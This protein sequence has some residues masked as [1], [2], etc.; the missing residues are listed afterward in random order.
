MLLRRDGHRVEVFGAAEA[1]LAALA[2]QSYDLLLTDLRMPGMDGLELLRAAQR[3]RPDLAVIL[4]T[5][6]G[7]VQSAVEAMK[8]GAYDY[9]TKPFRVEELVARLRALIRRASGNAAPVIE[10]GDTGIGMDAEHVARIFDPF[11]S[12][13]ADGVSGTGLGLTI[14]KNF[15]EHMGGDIVVDSAV[16]QGTRFRIRLALAETAIEEVA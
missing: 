13:R 3:R 4:M 16:N 15:V 2:E 12:R 6:F 1:F 5:A 7:T 11:F 10:I 9:L 8:H 14:V